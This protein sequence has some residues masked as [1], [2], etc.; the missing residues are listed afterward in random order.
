M[1]LS[2]AIMPDKTPEIYHAYQGEGVTLGKECVFMRLAFCTLS[3]NFCDS[4][5]TWNFENSGGGLPIAHRYAK[6]V[7]KEDFV[8][9][10][11]LEVVADILASKLNFQEPR[12]VISG[13]EPMIQ[14][15]ALNE[16]INEVLPRKYPELAKELIVEIETSGTVLS[17][18]D[19][20]HHIN[21]SPKLSSSGNTEKKRNVPAVIAEFKR[22]YETGMLKTLIFKFVVHPLEP[23]KFKEDEAEIEAWIEQHNIPKYLIYLMPEGITTDRIQKGSEIL[24]DYCNKKG[25]KFTTR[26]HIL[27]HGT[28]RAV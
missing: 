8:A 3:C 18:F 4:F 7:K 22:L 16:L 12:L 17:K 10:F 11:D 14:Q 24:L 27:L 23:D 13:G 28:K 26:L 9:D 25:Y 5:Y 2:L 20:F 1:K 19:F 21:C 15:Q 6:P